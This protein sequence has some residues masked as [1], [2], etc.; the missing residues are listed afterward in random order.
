LL[1]PAQHGLVVEDQVLADNAPLRVPQ[2]LRAGVRRVV[3]GVR[4]LSLAGEVLQI[5]EK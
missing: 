2:V 4:D 3:P 1:V 5:K